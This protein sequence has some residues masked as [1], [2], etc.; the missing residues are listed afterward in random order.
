M[1]AQFPNSDPA[2]ATPQATPFDTILAQCRDLVCERLCQAMSGMLDQVDAALSALISETRDANTQKLYA[3]TRDKALAQRAT[4][5]KQFR[6]RYLREF[7]Q[8]SNRVKKIGDSF[9]D[10]DLSSL[11]LELVGDEDLD[12]SLK[13]NAMAAKLR[14][15][16]DEE[17]IALDQRV[18]VLL[19]DASLQAEDNPFTP[20]A[21]CD[22][23]KDT[24]RQ[25]D[26]NVEVRMVMLRLFD[27]YVADEIRAVYKA[28][29]ALLVQNSILPKIR[30][31]ARK[32]TGKPPVR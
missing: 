8:R 3:Q 28:V 24:C 14:Q 12:E 11:E 7:Q 23:Y 5:E 18:G 9:S 31:Q 17:L 30:I 21:I 19:G 25:I 10:I 22:A 4:I 15:Y 16:C 1:P 20:Q 13:F 6:A 27:D 32:D 26:A 2:S 29:N